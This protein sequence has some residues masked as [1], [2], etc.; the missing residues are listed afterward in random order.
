M[1]L[2]EQAA[3]AAGEI[4]AGIAAVAP[5]DLD[6]LVAA[7]SAARRIALTG[8][9]RCDLIQPD[10]GR[11]GGLTE[12]FRIADMAQ[13]VGILVIPHGSSAYRYH[14]VSE[15]ENSQVAEFQMI[16][17]NADRI[18]PIYDLLL[19]GVLLP[20]CGRLKVPDA[21]GFG[22]SLNLANTYS[23]PCPRVDRTTAS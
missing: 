19:V 5:W 13:A 7:L 20:F 22:V 6:Q 16:S 14:F 18:V 4:A 10:V 17:L 3:R 11:C 1:D 21:P 23:R 15:K 8:A 12:L 2:A 9:G